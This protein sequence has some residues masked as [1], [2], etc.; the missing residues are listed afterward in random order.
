MLNIVIKLGLKRL[1]PNGFMLNFSA[2]M[3]R[4]GFLLNFSANT[5]RLVLGYEMISIQPLMKQDFQ[6]LPLNFQLHIQGFLLIHS[7]L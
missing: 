1:L 2:N 5:M 4:N 6:S 3:M 7:G